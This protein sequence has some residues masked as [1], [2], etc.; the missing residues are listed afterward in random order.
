MSQFGRFQAT[1]N[2]RRAG[3]SPP[4]RANGNVYANGAHVHS[5]VAGKRSRRG[6]AQGGGLRVCFLVVPL[7]DP[8]GH[9]LSKATWPSKGCEKEV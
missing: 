2:T 5:T 7:V 4:P 1:R 9:S 8:I 3:P 6:E